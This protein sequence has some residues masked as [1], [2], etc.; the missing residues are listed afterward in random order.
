MEPEARSA[1]G[2]DLP[3]GA[4]EAWREKLREG[5]FKRL[6]GGEEHTELVALRKRVR[7]L[8]RTLR[9]KAYELE[10]LGEEFRSWQ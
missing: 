10:I 5:G 4:F 7:D 2:G 6:S 1:V 8:K 9:R 3:R